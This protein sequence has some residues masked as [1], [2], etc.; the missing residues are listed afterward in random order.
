MSQSR[1]RL[2][3]EAVTIG[4]RYETTPD[5]MRYVLGKLR[6]PTYGH[7]KVLGEDIRI[8]FSGLGTSS[9]DV[10]LFLYVKATVLPDF[11]EIKE[12]LLLRIMDIVEQAGTGFAFPAQTAYLAKDKGLD[13][14][15]SRAAEAQV[16]R[17]RESGELPFPDLDERERDRLRD[18]LDYP[19]GVSASPGDS[20][21]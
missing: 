7:P 20:R 1:F 9:L 10:E 5:Q 11:M 8:R 4:R 18:Q 19:S 6:E 17:W 13:E 21:K 12:D 2:L 14:N 15:K 16:E 3:I